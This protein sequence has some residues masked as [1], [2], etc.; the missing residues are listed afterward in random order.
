MGP[1]TYWAMSQLRRTWRSTLGVALLVAVVCAVPTA[2]AA[3]ARRTGSVV[4]R[5]QRE[6]RAPDVELQIEDVDGSA[7]EA[8]R[9]LP[10]V[11]QVGQRGTVFL[12]PTG[13]GLK[14]FLEFF[15]VASVDG[16]TGYE[17]FRPRIDV[18]RLPSPSEPHEVL[19]SRPL[20]ERLDLGPGDRFSVD[21]LTLDSVFSFFETGGIPEPDGPTIELEVTGVGL[22]GAELLAPEQVP[23][24]TIL[25]TP[26][27]LDRYDEVAAFSD[28]LDVD[29]AGGPSS[30]EAFV[31]AAQAELDTEVLAT[32]LEQEVA[33]V[34]DGV[35]VQRTALL[36]FLAVAALAGV[37]AVAQ[38]ASRTAA[39]NDDD[40][41]TLAALGLGGRQ[42]VGAVVCTFL[43]AVAGGT[44][45]GLVLAVG[46]SRW[47]PFG[48]A[49]RLEPDPGIDLDW[50]VLAVGAATTAIGGL[51]AITV[52]IALNDR[53]RRQ[54]GTQTESRRL[55][56]LAAWSSPS[57]AIGVRWA[58]VSARGRT[59]TPV[60][61]ALA[62]TALGLGGTLAALS[63]GA[64]LDRIVATPER[65]GVNYDLDV[66]V[67]GDESTDAEAVD[68]SRELATRAEVG[69]LSV[70]RV[71]KVNVRGE[72]HD[73]FGIESVTGDIRFSVV[74]GRG[75]VADAEAVVG[76]SLLRKLG[77]GVGDEMV[78]EGGT[79]RLTIVGRGLF[80]PL[81]D[82]NSMA[83]G[84]GFTLPGL[85]AALD[86]LDDA[87]A[88]SGF[89]QALID[90]APG[91]DLDDLLR[92]YRAEFGFARL[93]ARPSSVAN[94]TE[95]ESVPPL[96]AAFLALLGVLALGH[97]V[98]ASVSRRR[99]DLAVLRA[100]GFEGRELAATVRAHAIT[101]VVI[102]IGV[103]V[104]LG[105]AAGRWA[106]RLVAADL[107]VATDP[108][109]TVPALAAI[110]TASVLLALLVATPS[111]RSAA[112]TRPGVVLRTE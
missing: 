12:R 58:L 9:A 100:V 107:G 36:V 70:L 38:A 53:R 104:P 46:A 8:I 48:L 29:L 6:L 26:A 11:T 28:I 80:P 65:Y 56:R 68:A 75:P 67:V 49:G 23:H 105:I 77:L 99:A 45:L 47:L 22:L 78:L 55:A 84:I 69:A 97:A 91:I 42:R 57:I 15:G 72:T 98:V 79:T 43:P 108:A 3:G 62:G 106:W 30:V 109:G 71:A 88:S 63:F 101:I 41:V 16:V 61:S 18:G 5:F 111:A 21:T 33:Q 32:P 87:A 19:V 94:L 54:P 89:P 4:D 50:L 39:R 25:F 35:A 60:R 52:S 66:G 102:G 31:E 37:V 40:L 103:G 74:E 64:S 34:R 83:T 110:V 95:A 59:A 86:D 7:T 93:A 90:A 73:A 2:A 92:S 82:A 1:V 24:G 14:P 81:D 17:I 76:T 27:F 13:T 112:R 85:A 20:A 96:I 51:L 10:G 44:G